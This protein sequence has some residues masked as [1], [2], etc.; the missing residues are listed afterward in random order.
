MISFFLTTIIVTNTH[1]VESSEP[2]F[3]LV[4]KTVG[5]GSYADYLF[6][7]K[8]HLARI[9][10]NVDVIIQDWPT[11][12]SELMFFRD[13]DICSIGFTGGGLDPDFTGVYDENGSL[14]LF[15]Y[16]TSMDWDDD[17][18]TGINEWY[19]KQ[20]TLIMP[21]DSEERIQHYWDWQQHLMDKLCPLKP[22][23]DPNW[24]AS[25]WANLNGFDYGK[26]VLQSW[27]QMNWSGTHLGQ[28]STNELVIA[29]SEWSDLNPLFQEFAVDAFMSENL[30]D[31][32]VWYDYDKS[33]W[34]HL[35]TDWVMIND[36]H[37][38]ISLREG[39]KWQ[40][41]P[42]GLFVNEYFDAED[43]YFT[44]FAWKHL[45]DDQ[46][47]WAWVKDMKILDQW[48]LDIF[49]DG[50]PETPDNEPYAPFLSSLNILMLPEHYLNQT[51]LADGITPDILHSSWFKF[52][53]DGFG[54]GLFIIDD[55]VEGV[56]TK[57]IVNNDCWLL[58]PLVD[59]SNIDFENRF[60]SFTSG[61]DSLRVKV[62]TNF[63]ST[64]LEYEIGKIDLVNLVDRHGKVD[65]YTQDP[66]Y[67][68]YTK[69]RDTLYFF[70]Y[71]MRESR[72]LIGNRDP[73]PS[74]ASISIGSAIRKA[75]S[76]A[77]DMVEINDVVHGGKYTINN[78]P[79]YKSLGVW[80]NPNIIRY[81]HD[82]DKAREYLTLAGYDVGYTKP[83][84]GLSLI[85]FVSIV[86]IV[87]SIVIIQRKKK[88]RR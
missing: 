77:I 57:L 85:A 75:I 21:P 26:G 4:A 54:T 12:Y 6:F 5:E 81:E 16:H 19:M 41:D 61:L 3:T 64:L 38:R 84:S 23:P 87:A 10:I 71:N 55:F 24:F 48:T 72:L 40:T 78:H 11:Y 83:G 73:C 1:E 69:I 82:L 62:I 49:I 17:L 63:E 66:N 59:K 8:Q 9:Q 33:A 50:N 29:R 20:G 67:K 86:S 37:A 39:I 79:I 46:H 27:G 13:F 32:L 25:S 30:M 68:M 22:L 45:S 28:T 7:L 60:G 53:T 51:Q 58:N 47:L 56:E 14:N 43:V 70:G 76:Y 18:G 65:Q 88:I 2:L 44:I 35:A 52:T 36:T 42:D 80:C 31:P 74:D 34:P 15:G